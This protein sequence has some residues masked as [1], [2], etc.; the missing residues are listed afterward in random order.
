MLKTKIIIL[1]SLLLPVLNTFSQD[2]DRDKRP[3]KLELESHLKDK[4]AR[5]MGPIEGHIDKLLPY[6]P[7]AGENTITDF[8]QENTRERLF[9]IDKK[10]LTTWT[11]AMSLAIPTGVFVQGLLAWDWGKDKKKFGFGSEGFFDPKSYS[12]GA[13]KTGHMM[14]HYI[15]KR[16][17]TWLFYN[18]GHDL[19]SSQM[20]GILGAGLTGLMI[21]I[22]DGMSRYR[23]SWEDLLMDTIGIT[24]GYFLDQY[25]A[26]DELIGLRWEWAPSKEYLDD[27]QKDKFDFNSD[28][29]GQ[30]F[31]LSLKAKGIPVLREKWYTRYLTLDVGY[32]TRGYKPDHTSGPMRDMNNSQWWSYG[33]GINLGSLITDLAPN[34]K[35]AKVMGSIT[36]YWVPPGIIYAGSS[37]IS[38]GKHKFK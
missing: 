31:Y 15:Q 37:N 32:F 30:K 34:S 17:Y 6:K 25:P 24:L 16:F 7:L 22:G 3:I 18:L 12:G 11:T 9:S 19:K 26:L 10:N 27:R 1:A 4:P 21:E 23:F 29:N 36:K 14:S 33:M 28:Y 13:D 2:I 5:L 20:F 38:G 35:I 8:P